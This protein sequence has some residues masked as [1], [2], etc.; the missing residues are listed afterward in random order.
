MYR[1]SSL[2]YDSSATLDDG[3]CTT[4]IVNGCTDVNAENYN[5]DAN[6]SDG[7][8]EYDL[9]GAGCQ[10]SFE[11]YNSGTNHTV[12]IPG[13][14]STP[15]S[16]GDQIG[17]FYIRDDGSAVCAGSSIWT[18]GNLQ[19]VAFGDDTTTPELDGLEVGSPF[20][21]IAQSGDDV[22]VVN[23]SFQSPE[24][25]TMQLMVYHLLQALILN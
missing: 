2:E 1:R 21:F 7:S 16:S 23:A 8:C 18:G 13:S 12:M 9:I 14:V 11:T 25:L 15:L 20:L 3:S 22:Y 5:P 19:I 6:T 17:V 24:W 4:L 10:V